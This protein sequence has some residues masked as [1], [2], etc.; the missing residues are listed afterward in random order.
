MPDGAN[1]VTPALEY[2]SLRPPADGYQQLTTAA[3]YG[4]RAEKGTAI[5]R[6]QSPADRDHVAARLVYAERHQ[7]VTPPSTTCK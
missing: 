3:P 7:L 6:H 4:P 1:T 5:G 2:F